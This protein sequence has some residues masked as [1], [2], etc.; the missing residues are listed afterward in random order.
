MT[1]YARAQ[2]LIAFPNGLFDATPTYSDVTPDVRDDSPLKV[3]R[4]RT[5]ELSKFDTGSIDCILDNGK[6]RYD[7]TNTHNIAP[8][9]GNIFPLKPVQLVG[10]YP[11]LPGLLP[12]EGDRNS[13]WV[14]SANAAGLVLSTTDGYLAGLQPPQALT[15]SS[16]A[17]GSSILWGPSIPCVVGG[18]L[19]FHFRGRSLTGSRN[20]KASIV[21]LNNVGGVVST[22]AGTPEAC[23][24]P[25]WGGAVVVTVVVPAGAVTARPVITAVAT[26]AAEVFEADCL[27]MDKASLYIRKTLMQAYADDWKQLW[28]GRDAWVVF[29]AT[30]AMATFAAKDINSVG[31]V[32]AI[33]SLAPTHYWR[34]SNGLNFTGLTTPDLGSV[35]TPAKIVGS[36]TFG[37]PGPLLADLG[38]AAGFF[39]TPPFAGYIDCGNVAAMTNVAYALGIWLQTPSAPGGIVWT[40]G[41]P[42]DPLSSFGSVTIAASAHIPGAYTFHAWFYPS[43]TGTGL[44]TEV[45]FDFIPPPVQPDLIHPGSFLPGDFFDLNWH[46]VW[47]MRQADQ[48]TYSIWVDGQQVKC[49]MN[50]PGMGYQGGDGLSAIAFGTM[51]YPPSKCLF[52]G[53][54]GQPT[55]FGQGCEIAVYQGSVLTGAQ[56]ANLYALARQAWFGQSPGQRIGAVLDVVGFPSA[57]RLLDP[58]SS[59]LMPEVG[60][61]Q[62][63]NAL[64]YIHYVE[65]SELG[66][67]FV[68]AAGNARFIARNSFTRP[69]LNAIAYTVGD[70]WPPSTT[71]LPLEDTDIDYGSTLVYTEADG[72]RQGGDTQSV[73]ADAGVLDGYGKRTISLSNM[74][75][76]SDQE[77]IG[78]LTYLVKQYEEPRLRIQKLILNPLDND[79]VWQMVLMLD[80]GLVIKVVLRPPGGGDPIEATGRVQHIDHTVSKKKWICE[81]ALASTDVQNYLILDDPTRGLLDTT[82]LYA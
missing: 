8:Y 40:Q 26:G 41:D 57:M 68:D 10:E 23:T 4:G 64:D 77:V 47:L 63:V 5:N 72:T 28:K 12:E 14:V 1:L 31:Y 30:D 22:L 9:A 37:V 11:W 61:L 82:N 38:S 55:M 70:V 32:T 53:Y 75:N 17:A 45:A 25:S 19:T 56:V 49:L 29:R 20:M 71:E 6:R 51:P 2:L 73:F 65:D 27:V 52:A 80:I 79:L 39:N 33:Q 42:T 36:I 78:L 54:N 44:K 24:T 43:G 62:K 16:V 69:P 67:F 50:Y 34:L 76:T 66:W 60:D 48:K 59:T 46:H 35:P 13:G 15:W 7:P 58:G 3:S 18:P 81:V 21:F 74:L